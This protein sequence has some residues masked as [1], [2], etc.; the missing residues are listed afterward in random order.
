[1]HKFTLNFGFR[2]TCIELF[3]ITGGRLTPAE[4]SNVKVDELRKW[5]TLIQDVSWYT[6]G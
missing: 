6:Y 5:Q 4:S 2:K 1:M 3:I